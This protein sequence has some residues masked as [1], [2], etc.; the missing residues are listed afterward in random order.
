MKHPV[1][2]LEKPYLQKI[3]EELSSCTDEILFDGFS[4]KEKAD[5]F[6]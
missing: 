6:T 2:G 3:G 5:L 4:E 1:Y